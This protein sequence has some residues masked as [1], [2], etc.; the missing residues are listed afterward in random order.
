MIISYS[1][2]NFFYKSKTSCVVTFSIVCVAISDFPSTSVYVSFETVEIFLTPVISP[3]GACFGS[4]SSN[5][6]KSNSFIR[7]FLISSFNSSEMILRK[8]RSVSYPFLICLWYFYNLIKLMKEWQQ[9]N[10]SKCSLGS[11]PLEITDS[12]NSITFR[13]ASSSCFLG[14]GCR[15]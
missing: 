12:V 9:F 2:S 11:S 14:V 1:F 6:P 7:F 13:F 4:G 10:L 8:V 15:I 3:M 5:L